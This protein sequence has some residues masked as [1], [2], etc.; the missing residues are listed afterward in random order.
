MLAYAYSLSFA[1]FRTGSAN[2]TWA[3]WQLN[4]YFTWEI[5]WLLSVSH[6]NKSNFSSLELFIQSFLQAIFYDR[7]SLCN[8]GITSVCL[9]N[10]RRETGTSAFRPASPLQYRLY[11]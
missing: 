1:E 4:I 3:T 8:P 11:S 7:V 2:Q 10:C 6:D 5:T 9:Q